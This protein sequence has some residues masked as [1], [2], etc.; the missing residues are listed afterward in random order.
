MMKQIE[1]AFECATISPSETDYV[2][3]SGKT[4]IPAL[5]DQLTQEELKAAFEAIHEKRAREM[6][7]LLDGR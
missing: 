2:V 7:R 5:I 1:V 4:Y 6:K 3:V